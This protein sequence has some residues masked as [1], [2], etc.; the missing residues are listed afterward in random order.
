MKK[1]AAFTLSTALLVA[2]GFGF[3]SCKEDE[4]PVPPKVSFAESA[5]T[6]DE[7]AGTIEIEVV[8]D[9]PYGKD[10]TIDIDFGGTANDQEDHGTANADYEVQGDHDA[11]TIESGETVGLI[12][13]DILP[14]AAFE[15]DETIEIRLVDTN[16]ADV[17]LT[18]DDEIV[19][20]I[21]NDDAQ[22][23]ASFTNTTMTVNE[24]D[25]PDPLVVTVGLDN[26]APSELIL[27]YTILREQ[28][29]PDARDSVSAW[30]PNPQQQLPFDYYINAEPEDI[31]QLIIPAGETSANIEIQIVSDLYFEG[32]ENIRIQ[33][34]GSSSATIGTNSLTT[35]TIKQEDG[36][37]IG[38]L[39]DPNYTDVDMDMFLYIGDDVGTLV[40]PDN[41]FALAARADTENQEEVIFLPKVFTDDILEAA[42]GLSYV[43]WG[44]TEDPMNFEVQFI[45]FADGAFEPEA[46]VEIFPATYTAANLNEWTNE[47]TGTDPVIVQTFRVVDGEYVDLTDITVPTEGSR[48]RGVK[49]PDGLRKYRW[50]ESRKLPF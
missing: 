40:F 27:E 2:M 48:T 30:N 9:K 46:G 39:W 12:T 35:I 16:T 10:L 22:V 38:L 25:G 11:V 28:N 15:E 4:P 47:D 13:I 34:T 23:V 37:V 8:L 44:G 19:I 14:D 20:T 50:S 21:T 7:D 26:P 43:Y 36:K 3:T 45:D 41:L 31:G 42:F 17:Q 32:D 6:V 1:Y 33:L 49:L 29:Q 24:A 18:S 5:M